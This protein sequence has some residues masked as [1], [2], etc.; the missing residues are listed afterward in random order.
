MA[1]ERRGV[2]ENLVDAGV[3]LERLGVIRGGVG[4]GLFGLHHLRGDAP[5]AASA[6]E[7][8]EEDMKPLCRHD[9]WK[10]CALCGMG[11]VINSRSSA[12]LMDAF[13]RDGTDRWWLLV[14]RHDHILRG[15]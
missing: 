4:L 13:S 1:T 5:S 10:N 9:G 3:A 2:E 12:G 7:E 6:A 15:G 14:P 8:Q 11:A